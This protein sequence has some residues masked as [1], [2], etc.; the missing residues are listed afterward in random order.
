MQTIRVGIWTETHETAIS[1]HM[2][3]HLTQCAEAVGQSVVRVGD[4]SLSR[5]G[6][7][8]LSRT[9]DQSLSRA[10]DQSLSRLGDQ[11]LRRTGDQ[12]QSRAGHPISLEAAVAQLY[13][14][15]ADAV[16][17]PLWQM[18]S[19]PPEG[20]AITAVLPRLASKIT[21]IIPDALRDSSQEFW[22]KLNATV[23]TPNV[24]IFSQLRSY[25]PD[26]TAASVDTDGEYVQLVEPAFWDHKGTGIELDPSELTPLAGAGAL[27]LITLKDDVQVRTQLKS[28]HHKETAQ[29]T[30]VERSFGRNVTA[31]AAD[32]SRGVAAHCHRDQFGNYHGSFCVVSQDGTI[33]RR[34]FSHNTTINLADMATEWAEK[35]DTRR[36][37]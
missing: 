9:G 37:T 13:A 15:T 36:T 31:I 4:Q 10:G 23:A 12:S 22:V 17:V 1:D 29:C 11:S 5:T 34:M 33:Q 19:A 16:L 7:Q 25:R 2:Y 24:L 26:L 3:A 6:D 21:L 20:C 14:N 35:G 32:Q 28:L 8:S 27:A 30:N 18:P